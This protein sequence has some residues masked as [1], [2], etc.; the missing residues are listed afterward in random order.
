MQLLAWICGP[1]LAVL[2]VTEA[3]VHWKGW[4]LIVH[5]RAGMMSVTLEF[6]RSGLELMESGYS[7]V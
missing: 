2:A 4:M 6:A 7:Y 1:F 3:R 5:L